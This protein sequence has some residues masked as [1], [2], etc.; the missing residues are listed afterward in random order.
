MERAL[1]LERSSELTFVAR[2]PSL[3]SADLL[4]RTGQ[5]DEARRRCASL[6]EQASLEGDEVS[7]GLLHRNL[8]WIDLLAGEWTGSRNHLEQAISLGADTSAF[9]TRAVLEALRGDAAAATADA[10]GC[11]D[12]G[13]PHR[14]DRR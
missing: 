7:A 8:G 6:L 12:G 13:R 14:I 4:T 5:I 9:A 2:R 10:E 3:G 11:P 1:E